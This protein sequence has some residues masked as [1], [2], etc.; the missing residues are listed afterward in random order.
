MGLYGETKVNAIKNFKFQVAE[1]FRSLRTNIRFSFAGDEI[2]TIVVTSCSPSEG[3]STVISNLAVTMAK[4]GKKV[5]IVDCDLRKPNI[6][7]MFLLSNSKGLTNVLVKDKEIEDVIIETRIPNL[8]VIPSG[9]IPPNPSELLSS[10][11]IKE[12]LSKLTEKFDM[13]LIDTPPVLYISDAQIMSALSQGTILVI[14]Y[15]KTDKY[16]L[17]NAKESIE[18]AGGNILGV[19][20]NKIPDKY[21]GGYGYNYGDK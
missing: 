15:G 14:A 3:K 5:L 12:V 1:Q 17:L 16:Q 21:N 4:S 11:I 20:I 8:Y 18:K 7:R 9:Q 13:V 2:K 6:H 10:E 19:V